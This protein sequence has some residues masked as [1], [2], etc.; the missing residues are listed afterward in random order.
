[1]E[2]RAKGD[3]GASY[4]FDWVVSLSPSPSYQITT[5]FLPNPI[6]NPELPLKPSTNLYNIPDQV[7]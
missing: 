7:R 6:A 2:I 3:R 5:P 4:L 1:M